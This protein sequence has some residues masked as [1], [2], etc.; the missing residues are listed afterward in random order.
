M[1][2]LFHGTCVHLNADPLFLNLQ[3]RDVLVHMA[4]RPRELET[5]TSPLERLG[6]CYVELSLDSSSYLLLARDT[7]ALSYLSTECA[8]QE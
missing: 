3:V 7:R 2:F 1:T 6:S 5:S 4:G 8:P